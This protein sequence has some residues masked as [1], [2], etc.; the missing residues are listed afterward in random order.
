MKLVIQI[1]CLNE[2]ASLAQTIADLPRHIDG[3][4]EI[5]L[6]VIDDG[7]TDRTVEVAHAAG[8]HHV[9]RHPVNKGLAA[10][11]QSGLNAAL[12]LGAD[13]IVNTDADN[14]YQGRFLASLVYP[15]LTQQA[16]IVI[17]DRQTQ[18]IPHF[19][20]SKKF[21]QQLGSAVVRLVSKTNIPDAPSGFRAFS[22]EAA[23]RINVLTNYTYTLETIIQAGQNNLVVASVPIKTNVSARESRLIKSTSTYILRSSLTIINL[24]ILYQPLRLFSCLAVPFFVI[25]AGLWL[26][27]LSFVLQGEAGSGTHVQSV[28]VGATLV[29]IAFF[30]FLIGLL[31]NLISINRRMHEEALY[32]AKRAALSQE[33]GS[34][35]FETHLARP[36]TKTQVPLPVENA[37][38]K[39]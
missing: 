1:P 36:W 6:L 25:G 17:G 34:P 7:S 8:A 4:D 2:E 10:A 29:I 22:R 15:I 3:I 20:R 13:V 30:I 16:D 27:Y 11:F 39:R 26:W 5:E 21:L 23:L 9:I 28:I 19:S 12:Y 33:N 35:Q 18:L 37:E 14:Q 24:F 38:Q 31:G 32:Y